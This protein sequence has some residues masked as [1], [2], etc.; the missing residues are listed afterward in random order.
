MG[1]WTD[2][3]DRNAKTAFPRT[4]WAG[5]LDALMGLSIES[6]TYK[7]EDTSVRHIGPT[8]QDF[9]AAFGVGTDDTHLA[10]LDRAVGPG[11]SAARWRWRGA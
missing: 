4:G 3:S 10:A 8:A 9:H 1:V 11:G 7:N 2:V 6:W 5:L